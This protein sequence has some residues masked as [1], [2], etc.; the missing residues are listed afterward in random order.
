MLRSADSV[1]GT[2]L[3]VGGMN[4]MRPFGNLLELT[5]VADKFQASKYVNIMFAVR[6]MKPDDV[7]VT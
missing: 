2:G 4:L 1:P 3:A 7:M 5:G 6:V